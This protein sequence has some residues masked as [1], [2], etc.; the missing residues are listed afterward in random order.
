VPSSKYIVFFICALFVALI[1]LP[2]FII[3]VSNNQ[4]VKH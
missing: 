4:K 2:Y 3:I 1:N